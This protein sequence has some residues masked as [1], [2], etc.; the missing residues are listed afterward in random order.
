MAQESNRA[1]IMIDPTQKLFQG[2]HSLGTTTSQDQCD[3]IH[4]KE[5]NKLAADLP[6]RLI[7]RSETARSSMIGMANEISQEVATTSPA[8]VSNSCPQGFW[9]PSGVGY[10]SASCLGLSTAK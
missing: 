7:R 9:P 6:G 3:R 5:D 2:L 4:N 1:H 10:N 8:P